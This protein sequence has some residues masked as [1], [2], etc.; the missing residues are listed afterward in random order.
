MYIPSGDGPDKLQRLDLYRKDCFVLES[1]QGQD[2]AAPPTLPGLTAS[3]AV[4]RK[5]RQ[6]EDAMQRA[7]R[8]A[9]NYIRCL[10]AAEGR[11]PLLIVADVGC[12]L[13]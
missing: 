7:R 2:K 1:K 13:T 3:S 9:E 5:T 10:P 6:W 12:Y 11:P 4:K 8:Q